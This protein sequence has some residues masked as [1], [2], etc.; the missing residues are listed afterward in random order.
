MGQLASLLITGLHGRTGGGFLHKL[1]TI[2]EWQD[3]FL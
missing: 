2:A 3:W 1:R